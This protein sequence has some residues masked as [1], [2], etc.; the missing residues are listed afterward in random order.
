M[1]LCHET[2][3]GLDLPI[4]RSHR[5]VKADRSGCHP[6]AMDTHRPSFPGGFTEE[7]RNTWPWQGTEEFPGL[8]A[9]RGRESFPHEGQP[10]CL[11]PE[12]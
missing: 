4:G 2:S 1:R 12:G 5:S 9:A 8:R 6:L 7:V 3:K 10:Q 11:D